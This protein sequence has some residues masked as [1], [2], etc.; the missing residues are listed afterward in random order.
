MNSRALVSEP[1]H[2]ILPGRVSILV[3][4][5]RAQTRHNGTCFTV[6]FLLR[7]IASF[8]IQM[9]PPTPARPTLNWI[10]TFFSWEIWRWTE[11]R[12]RVKWIEYISHEKMTQTSEISLNFWIRMQQYC[13]AICENI[14]SRQTRTKKFEFDF[15]GEG[16]S[17]ETG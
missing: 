13:S 17:V 8:C 10:F 11:W 4:T 2:S 16:N 3:R 14:E 1:I 5:D 15:N 9:T 7:T 6:F 12:A